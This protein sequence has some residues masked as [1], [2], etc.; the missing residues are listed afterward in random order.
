MT[1]YIY[2]SAFSSDS[3]EIG[4]TVPGSN[5]I[6]T[7][8]RPLDETH[9]V[10]TPNGS[11]A[12]FI[13]RAAYLEN[14]LRTEKQPFFDD[15]YGIKTVSQQEIG[16]GASFVVL[17]AQISEEDKEDTSKYKWPQRYVAIK[18]VKDKVAIR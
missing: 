10:S 15:A 1:T 16:S 17:K 12:S 13:C 8:S 14:D 7:T 6:T 3:S 18:R 9:V 2:R 5:S 4:N 11:L